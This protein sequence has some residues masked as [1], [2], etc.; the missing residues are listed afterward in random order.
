MGNAEGQCDRTLA[1]SSEILY[2]TGSGMEA[3]SREENASEQESKAGF[4]FNQ[5]PA[6][7]GKS[8]RCGSNCRP[9]SV[10]SAREGPDLLRFLSGTTLADNR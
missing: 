5:N 3:R 1:F 4:W 6:L 7:E 2:R 8:C 9:R 10:R